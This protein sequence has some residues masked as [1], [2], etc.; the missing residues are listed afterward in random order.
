MSSEEE[1]AKYWVCGD[2]PTETEIRYRNVP[3]CLTV[4]PEHE[5]D[6]LAREETNQ[7]SLS[8]GEGESFGSTG[9]VLRRR[10]GQGLVPPAVVAL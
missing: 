10:G 1:A 5:D 8:V 7:A 9:L 2:E 3:L 4:R 6:F